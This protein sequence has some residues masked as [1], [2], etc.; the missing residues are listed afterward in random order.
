MKPTKRRNTKEEKKTQTI[1]WSNS[2]TNET[3]EG[4]KIHTGSREFKSECFFF[5]YFGWNFFFV[6]LPEFG[7]KKCLICSSPVGEYFQPVVFFFFF[8][9]YDCWGI[10]GYIFLRVFFLH[11]IEFNFFFSSVC[12]LFFSSVFR[13]AHM[14]TISQTNEKSYSNKQR[15]MSLKSFYSFVVSYFCT[16][17]SLCV[18]LYSFTLNKLIL[19]LSKSNA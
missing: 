1:E 16:T 10:C 15:K 14:K 5:S 18:F 19:P 7:I 8:L 6:Y 17:A 9:S 13:G 12:A 4:K 2:L 11:F 3:I